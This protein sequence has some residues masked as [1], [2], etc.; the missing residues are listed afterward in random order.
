[1]SNC[2]DA[3]WLIEWCHLDNTD[4]TMTVELAHRPISNSVHLSEL[5]GLRTKPSAVHAAIAQGLPYRAWESFLAT[6]GLS[7]PDALEWVHIAPRTL[8]RRKDEG[9][10]RP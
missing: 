4:L 3:K 5:L 7:Q 6:T 2:I 8:L 9:Q 10:L 1:M